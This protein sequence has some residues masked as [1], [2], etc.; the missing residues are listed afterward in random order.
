M[1]IID[2]KRSN[3]QIYMKKHMKAEKIYITFIVIFHLHFFG[4]H[5]LPEKLITYIHT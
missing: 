1:H 2:N 5:N 4:H 3:L